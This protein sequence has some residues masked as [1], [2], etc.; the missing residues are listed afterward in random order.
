MNI[1]SIIVPV[2]RV[3]HTLDRCINS[4]VNQNYTDWELILVDDGSP[5]NSPAICDRWAREDD[6]ITVIHKKNGGLS[7]ARN[8]GLDVARG[9]WIMF[10]DSDDYIANDTLMP[11]MKTMATDETIDILEYPV[12]K[13]Y[14]TGHIQRLTFDNVIYTDMRTYWLENKAYAHSY[15][16]NKVYKRR[17]F[18]CERYTEGRVF[19]DID[20]YPRLLAQAQVVEQ[21]DKGEY[22][23]VQNKKGITANASA[24]DQKALLDAH[25]QVLRTTLCPK[26]ETIGER[27]YYMH[28]VDI[29]MVVTEMTGGGPTLPKT[30]IKIQGLKG[31]HKWKAIF[32]NIAG[33]RLLCACNYYFRRIFPRKM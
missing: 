31:N 8:A 2:Y 30:H 20:I 33:L 7:S 21:T 32:I 19:E 15:A 12:V 23:Y 28:I 1:L 25:L 3:E 18:D 29:Q 24:A 27:T 16:W 22:V 14:P 26:V 10:V 6:R 9:K 11:L 17:L 5:D 13:L 4:I